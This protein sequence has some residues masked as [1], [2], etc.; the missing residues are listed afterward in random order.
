MPDAVIGRF[1]P[2]HHIEHAET[3]CHWRVATHYPHVARAMSRMVG[4]PMDG[5]SPA[6]D[7]YWE[8]VTV[9]SSVRIVF[10][11]ADNTSVAFRVASVHD[12]GVFLFDSGCWDLEEIVGGTTELCTRAAGTTLCEL[13]LQPV[14]FTTRTGRTVLYIKPAIDVI[15]TWTSSP[16]VSA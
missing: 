13:S 3:R 9:S 16:A 12:L 7:G 2:G 4:A 5:L 8:L 10:E 1:H 14:L 11:T 15:G 6:A